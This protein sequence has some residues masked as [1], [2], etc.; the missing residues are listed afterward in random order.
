MFLMY[1]SVVF[2]TVVPDD[3]GPHGAHEDHPPRSLTPPTQP[4]QAEPS[5]SLP[6]WR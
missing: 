4:V 6:Q 3:M 5:P 2:A 1:V